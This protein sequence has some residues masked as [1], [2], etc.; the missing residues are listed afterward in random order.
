VLYA[1]ST[2]YHGSWFSSGSTTQPSSC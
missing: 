2:L 1:A